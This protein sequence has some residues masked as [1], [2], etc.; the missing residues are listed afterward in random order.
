[1]I[2]NWPNSLPPFHLSLPQ[3]L[4]ELNRAVDVEPG[5]ISAAAA[6]AVPDAPVVIISESEDDDDWGSFAESDTESDPER[7]LDVGENGKTNIV[8]EISQTPEVTESKP[9]N[10]SEDD[11]P[12]IEHQSKRPRL[13]SDTDTPPIISTAEPEHSMPPQARSSASG[14][15]RPKMHKSPDI[16]L[17]ISPYPACILALGYRDHRWVARWRKKLHCEQWIDEL[18]NQSYSITFDYQNPSDWKEKLKQV[19]DFA[20]S[21]WIIGRDNRVKGLQ[22]QEGFAEQKPG[23]IPAYVFDE[24]KDIVATMPPK[25]QYVR[26]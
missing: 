10:P 17:P 20:W 24:L 4:K 23:E 9:S 1:M 16:L 2:I 26:K 22:L 6:A 25:H 7:D 12:E 5:E 11:A 18:A 3:G 19:H 21:K 14:V 15:A 8:P 13:A